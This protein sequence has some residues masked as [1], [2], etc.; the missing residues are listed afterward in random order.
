MNTNLNSDDHKMIYMLYVQ[1]VHHVI[2]GGCGFCGRGQP[3]SLSPPAHRPRWTG[4][5][6]VDALKATKLASFQ[7]LARFGPHDPATYERLPPPAL[8]LGARLS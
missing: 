6:P 4:I 3:L 7:V 5:Y 2:T 1:A 8:P